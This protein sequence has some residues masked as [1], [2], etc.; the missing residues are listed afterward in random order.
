MSKIALRFCLYLSPQTFHQLNLEANGKLRLRRFERILKQ[1]LKTY[2][3]YII[4]RRGLAKG[5]AATAFCYVWS[6]YGLQL[7]V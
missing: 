4:S 6:H 3:K 5:A 2:I 7:S 1:P